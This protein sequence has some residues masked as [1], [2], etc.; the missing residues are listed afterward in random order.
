MCHVLLL[1]PLLALPVFWIWPLEVALPLYAA[2]A[3]IAFAVYLFAWKASRTPLANGPQALVGT[4]GPVVSVGA[5]RVTLRLGGELWTADI[6]GALPS[7]GERAVVV[8]YEGL[9]FRARRLSEIVHATK[10]KP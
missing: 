5:R 3:A 10:E 9:C 7:P 1:L 4:T 8:S 2:A 6:D